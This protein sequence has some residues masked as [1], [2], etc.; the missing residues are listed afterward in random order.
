MRL[1]GIAPNSNIINLKVLDQGGNGTDSAVIAAIDRAVS[2]KTQYNIGVIN[3]SLGRPITESYQLDPLC[4]AAV[5]GKNGI[6]VVVAAGNYGRFNEFG[7]NGYGTITAPGND[8]FVIT[9]GA[10]N[11]EG[12]V[13]REDDRITSYS[14]KGPSAF[15]HIV[16]PDLVAPGNQFLWRIR[17]TSCSK[18]R[19]AW[20]N[21]LLN[22]YYGNPGKGYS[23][24]ELFPPERHQHYIGRKRRSRAAFLAGLHAD[25]RSRSSPADADMQ[26]VPSSNAVTDLHGR[27]LHQLLRYFY[28]R[29]SLPGCVGSGNTTRATGIALSPSAVQD[30]T[31]VVHLVDTIP[32][33]ALSAVWTGS[34]WSSSAVWGSSQ[35]AGFQRWSPLSAVWGSS[36]SLGEFTGMGI[37]R[38]LG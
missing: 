18:R 10:M 2:L 14:S 6:T 31:G 7:N 3:I 16:K 21:S 29:A 27:H 23:T 8:P 36:R 28:D 35:F 22:S 30:S 19:A 15:D 38:G 11:D 26:V 20:G 5:R 17:A 12:T 25:A 9:V 32:N 13:T 33:S 34:M 1:R 4:Q 24:E 37:V